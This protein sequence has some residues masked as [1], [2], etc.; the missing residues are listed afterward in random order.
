MLALEIVGEAV[1]RGGHGAVFTLDFNRSDVELVTDAI[2]RITPTGVVSNDG[3][4]REVDAIILA[5]GFETQQFAS[6]VDI[7]GRGGQSLTNAWKNGSEAHYGVTTSGFPNLFMLYGPNTNGGNSIILMLEYQ[8]EFMMRLLDEADHAGATWLEVKRE[9][10]D[11]YNAALQE[12]LDSVEV[13][14]SGAN[15]Y[16]R[17]AQG[18]IVT[19]WPHNFARY[20][21][22]VEKVDLSSFDVG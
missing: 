3:T 9:V 13:W 4:E 19:Q 14:R 10:M 16:Y 8:I 6:V 22:R 2:A 17:S 1:R 21:E 20:S 7:Y 15:D 11:S 12:E 5:T 18:N